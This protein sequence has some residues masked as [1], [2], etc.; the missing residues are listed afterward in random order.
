MK[1]EHEK[2]PNILYLS[3]ISVVKVLNLCYNKTIRKDE[4]TWLFHQEKLS[5]W[6]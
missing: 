2:A 1:N 4:K 3:H 5:F 6:S